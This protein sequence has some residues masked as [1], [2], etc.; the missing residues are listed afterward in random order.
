M[1]RAR[2]LHL[3]LN[4]FGLLLQAVEVPLGGL[5]VGEGLDEAGHGHGVLL[6]LSEG[7]IVVGSGGEDAWDEAALG[8]GCVLVLAGDDDGVDGEVGGDVPHLRRLL[9]ASRD[10]LEDEVIE[11]VDEYATDFLVGEG[12]EE[13]R[14][15]VHRDVVV[16]LVV[17]DTGRGEVLGGHLTDVARQFCEER[18]VLQERDE[19]AIEVVVGL[20]L[21]EHRSIL[22]RF[23]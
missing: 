15:P 22:P 18:G 14:V 13:L 1:A 17:G 5:G 12:G 4:L 23:P 8:Q 9:E 20:A 7:F 11:L 19:V 21:A 16:L 2:L 10:V 6:F 3:L